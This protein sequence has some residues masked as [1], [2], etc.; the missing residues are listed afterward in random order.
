LSGCD[1][2][3]PGRHRAPA[4]DLYRAEDAAEP[5]R[6]ALPVGPDENTLG[7]ERDGHYPM[8]C[9]RSPMRSPTVSMPT[10]RRTRPA[11][12]ASLVPRTEACVIG[13]GTSMS[14]STPPSDSP[15]VK[16]SVRAE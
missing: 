12:G 7:L 8:A 10:E 9:A 14:D 16:I 1:H 4:E 2:P 5:D 11:G 3:R 13:S 15:S 6:V